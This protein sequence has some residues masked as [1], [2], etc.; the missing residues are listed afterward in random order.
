MAA[1]LL[2][3]PV[4]AQ[5]A[6]FGYSDYPGEGDRAAMGCSQERA[7]CIVVRCDDDFSVGLYIDTFRESGDAGPWRIGVDRENVLIL[8]A[9][10]AGDDLPYNGRFTGDT[11]TV[12]ERLKHGGVVFLEAMSGDAIGVQ[13]IPLTGSLAAINEAL[14]YCAPRVPENSADGGAEQRPDPGGHR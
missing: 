11:A 9:E 13:R 12:I 3:A 10:P 5:P 1:I 4:L 6:G 7:A 8:E 2:A 14:Y